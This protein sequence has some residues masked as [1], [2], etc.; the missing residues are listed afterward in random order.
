MMLN[1]PADAGDFWEYAAYQQ[2][3]AASLKPFYIL[4]RVVTYVCGDSR[5]LT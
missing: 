2:A 4:R 1:V 3:D 5:A